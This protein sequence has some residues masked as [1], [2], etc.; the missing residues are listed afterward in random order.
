[1][2]GL[3]QSLCM[4]AIAMLLVSLVTIIFPE[5]KYR[6]YLMFMT[7]VIIV[8]VT[9]TVFVKNSSDFEFST[10]QQNNSYSTEYDA[11]NQLF[12]IIKDDIKEYIEAS[13]NTNCIVNIN[14][15]ET[16]IYISTGNEASIKNAVFEKFGI[17]SKVI[18]D[19]KQFETAT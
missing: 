2:N 15:S 4:I 8:I 14:E 7:K 1:M 6:K 16:I 3:T 12:G 19:E 13:F 5:N 10:D 9:I 18:K 17:D 11:Q